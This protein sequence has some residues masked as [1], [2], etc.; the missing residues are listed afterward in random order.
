MDQI[1][2]NLNSQGIIEEKENFNSST[3]LPDD[4]YHFETEE[5]FNGNNIFV[6]QR[7]NNTN[8]N[9][10]DNVLLIT[11][12]NEN[13]LYER[14]LDGHFNLAGYT[15]E[16]INTTTVLLGMGDHVEIFNIAENKS[17]TLSIEGHHDYEYNPI[18]KTIFTLN[19]YTKTNW[20]GFG[21]V[22]DRISEYNLMGQL[23]WTLKSDT[24]IPFNHWNGDEWKGLKADITHGNTIFFDPEEEML[25]YNARNTN[26]FYKIN[27]IS[28]EVI[29]GLGENGDFQLIDKNGMTRSNLFYHPHAVEKINEDTFILFDND[30]QNKTNPANPRSRLVEIQIDEDAM[31]AHEVWSWQAPTE[32]YSPYWGD[33]DRLPNGNRMG[34]FGTLQHPDGNFGARLVEVNSKGEI[35]WEHSYKNSPTY[36]YGIYRMERFRQTPTISKPQDVIDIEN[37]SIIIEWDSMFNYRSKWKINGSYTVFLNDSVVFSGTHGFEKFWQSSP[38]SYTFSNLPLGVYNVS[39]LLLNADGGYTTDSINI[40]IVPYFI[41]SSGPVSFERGEKSSVIEWSGKTNDE[42]KIE[43]IINGSLLQTVQW[44]G[45]NFS[46]DL[47]T[48]DLGLHIIMLQQNISITNISIYPTRFYNNLE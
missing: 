28:R 8:P 4:T 18:S 17:T 29:W 44:N 38:I 45:E 40:S 19:S 43:L 32:Y 31:T 26:T 41:K 42:I 15:V 13:T 35:V 36:S 30:Y 34:T 37:S 6:M 3:I 27:H 5:H 10:R 48:L 22:Y 16:F 24:F 39:I 25:Y 12:D 21:Y 9:D 46:L 33:A 7:Q 2:T 20:L 1:R 23:L 11:D 14:I 47:T